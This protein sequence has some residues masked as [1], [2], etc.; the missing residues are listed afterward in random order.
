M[1]AF[2]RYMRSFLR[3][4]GTD[5][6]AQAAVYNLDRTATDALSTLE[7]IA[8]RP[9][10][11]SHAGFVLLMSL[12]IIGPRE[13]RELAAV[14]RL[15]KGAI[16]SSVDT[17]ERRG[18]VARTRSETDRRLV[19]VSLTEAGRDLIARV[20]EDWHTLEVKVTAGLTDDEKQTLASLCRKVAHTARNMRL[21]QR[22]GPSS[23]LPDPAQ[24]LDETQE[25]PNKLSSRTTR[26]T[27]HA[28]KPR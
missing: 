15:T 3:E 5:L 11:L 14:L 16:V 20:Q 12:W 7:S 13:T 10:D 28:A 21:A 25:L 1:P 8:L 4:R 22:N 24:F 17:L 18:L 27:A 6:D 26:R 2:E 9:H 23:G 19:S